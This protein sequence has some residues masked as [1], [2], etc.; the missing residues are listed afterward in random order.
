LWNGSTKQAERSRV[1][2]GGS[3]YG[4]EILFFPGTKVKEKLQGILIEPKPQ[5][6]FRQAPSGDHC[7][8]ASTPYTVSGGT[9]TVVVQGP[10]KALV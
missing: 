2:L 7:T 10:K 8:W 6:G 3:P 5:I 4:E 9:W 1:G